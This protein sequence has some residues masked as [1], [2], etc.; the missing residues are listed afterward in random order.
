MAYR[1]H[2]RSRV[3]PD[4]C[5]CARGGCVRAADTATFVCGS[6]PYSSLDSVCRGPRQSG[7]GRD[8]QERRYGVGSVPSFVS[9]SRRPAGDWMLLREAD[10]LKEE[11]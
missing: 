11:R 5:L 3:T 8:E 4:P 6:G 10:T 2:Y 9:G 1:L 7:G